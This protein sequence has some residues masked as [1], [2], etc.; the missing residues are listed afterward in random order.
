MFIFLHFITLKTFQQHMSAAIIV[1]ST[2]V[3]II[4][5]INS[6]QCGPNGNIR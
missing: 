5:Y 3:S 6:E 2:H 1:I 4:V